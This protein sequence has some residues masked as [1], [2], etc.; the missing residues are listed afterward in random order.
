MFIAHFYFRYLQSDYYE[1][2]TSCCKIEFET[3]LH[4][5][6]DIFFSILRQVSVCNRCVLECMCYEGYV[7]INIYHN[8]YNLT[9]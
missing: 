6:L 3:H 8:L 4:F 9:S 2:R 7:E 1:T 5:I